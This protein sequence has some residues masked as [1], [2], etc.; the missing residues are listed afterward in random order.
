MSELGAAVADG[1]AGATSRKGFLARLGRF[2][3]VAT[4]GSAVAASL[5]AEEAQGFHF[6]GHIFT[7]DSCPHP[8]GL[9]RV[10]ARGYALRAADGM[11]VDNLGRPVDSRGWPLDEAGR[12]LL[13]PDGLPLPPAPRTHLCLE[14]VRDRVDL[15]TYVDGAWYRCCG[16][17]VRK[18]IDCCTHTRRRVNGDAAL[19]GYC[20]RGRTVYC[21]MYYDTNVPC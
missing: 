19:A 17:K 7:T 5:E 6:C 16:G 20:Y 2:L 15:V 10:D 9:P 13:D 4:G 3:L 18:L 12:P 14:A 1:V 11:P 8:T 21:V